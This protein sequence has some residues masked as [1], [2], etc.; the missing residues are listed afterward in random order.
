ML[1]IVNRDGAFAT[2]LSIPPQ[3]LHEVPASLADEVAVF[4]EPTA[5]ACEILTQV[6]VTPSSRVAVVG[7]GGAL[8]GRALHQPGCL[9]YTSDAADE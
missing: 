9:L 1:G 5:A 6:E 8:G 3:N 7:D 4:V 2:H